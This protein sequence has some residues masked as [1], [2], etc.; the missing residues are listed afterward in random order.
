MHSAPRLSV[1]ADC[2]R[3]GGPRPAISEHAEVAIVVT[4]E[5]A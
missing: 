1:S 3:L 5:D 2:R 4:C